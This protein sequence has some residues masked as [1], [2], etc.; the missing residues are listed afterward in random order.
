MQGY[1]LAVGLL[2]NPSVEDMEPMLEGKVV[3]NSKHLKVDVLAQTAASAHLLKRVFE[4]F[5]T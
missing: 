5:S 4:E 1:S 2:A 3:T